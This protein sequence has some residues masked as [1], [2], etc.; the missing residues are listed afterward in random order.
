MANGIFNHLL[1]LFF[2][3]VDIKTLMLELKADCFG[4]VRM[5]GL[6]P[7]SLVINS[8]MMFLRKKVRTEAKRHSKGRHIHCW[9]L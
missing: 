6:F 1:S 7:S 4:R 5:S 2:L 8:W 3:I 9:R